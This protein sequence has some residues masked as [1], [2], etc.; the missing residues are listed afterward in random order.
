MERRAKFALKLLVGRL[1]VQPG[2]RPYSGL[3]EV[4]RVVQ[5]TVGLDQKEYYSVPKPVFGNEAT[6][7]LHKE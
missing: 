3:Q 6:G 1:L 7:P 2:K 5:R 4:R